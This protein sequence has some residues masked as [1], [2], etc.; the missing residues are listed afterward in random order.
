MCTVVPP[1]KP[2]KPYLMENASLKFAVVVLFASLLVIGSLQ[3]VVAN[4]SS[5]VNLDDLVKQIWNIYVEDNIFVATV[6]WS[7]FE[8]LN[9]NTY[10][11]WLPEDINVHVFL[12]ESARYLVNESDRLGF[13][14]SEGCSG[15]RFR[16]YKSMK[17]WHIYYLRGVLTSSEVDTEFLD[18][19]LSKLGV[20]ASSLLRFL[21]VI[22][23]F[24]AFLTVCG[25]DRLIYIDIGVEGEADP[26]FIANAVREHLQAPGVKI[27]VMESGHCRAVLSRVF[28]ENVEGKIGRVIGFGTT[29]IGDFITIGADYVKS[30]AAKYNVSEREV[31]KMI[32]GRLFELFS[33][34]PELRP[35]SGEKLVI[36]VGDISL[37]KYEP[38]VLIEP[39][40]P[41]STTPE[42]PKEAPRE[43]TTT[44]ASATT[45]PAS[46]KAPLVANEAATTSPSESSSAQPP[47]F[48]TPLAASLALGAAAIAIATWIKRR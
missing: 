43:A 10:V 16:L 33:S 42:T 28:M 38:L 21:D 46:M 4:H 40:N 24:I 9:E 15:E 26:L 1:M 17:T 7:V 20:K 37:P 27:Q 6:N 34:I 19:V 45:S 39:I 14:G 47:A 5:V 22:R 35:S 25:G 18:Q 31:V 11:L 48:L 36:V 13:L 29:F 12:D 3:A 30:T 8:K 32:V 44:V 23:A 2:Y 41:A